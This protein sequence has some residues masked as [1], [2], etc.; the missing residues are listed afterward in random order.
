T[1]ASA[2][3]AL[4]QLRSTQQSGDEV[5]NR[6]ATGLR[7]QSAGDN[8]AFFLVS[9]K[10]RGDLVVLSGLRDNLGQQEGIFAAAL[11]GARQL[12]RTLDAVAGVITAAQQGVALDELEVAFNALL[13]QASEALSSAG[14]QDTNLLRDDSANTTVIGLDR[15]GNGLGFQ[16]IGVQGRDLDRFAYD[17]SGYEEGTRFVIEAESYD[18][19]IGNRGYA[20]EESE[21]NAGYLVWGDDP[22]VGQINYATSALARAFA[23][24]LDYELEFSEAGRYYFAFRGIGPDE[25]SNSI[26]IGIDGTPL[27]ANSRVTIDDPSG[28]PEWGSETQ[29]LPGTPATIDIIAPGSYTL[30]I[31]G[32]ENRTL[33]D[34]F[35][36]SLDT[37][38]LTGES[39]ALGA[40]TAKTGSTR[41]DFFAHL[42]QGESRISTTGFTEVL[43]TLRPSLSAGF[44]EQA[45]TVLDGLRSKLNREISQIGAYRER[46]V[47]Q[48]R[49]LSDLTDAL[50]L[51]VASLVEADL[52]VEA[53]R[54]AAIEV[55]ERLTAQSLSIANQRPATILQ[56]FR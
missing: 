37:T 2:Q 14:F 6:L 35:V 29:F 19:N 20:W 7:I 39:E 4:V 17:A 27:T 54:L 26:H 38:Q 42:D 52:Q 25:Q 46:I 53:S 34:G 32:R 24:R 15:S 16:T 18:L 56:L 43:S 55:Q 48:D 1:N 8:P 50:D 28:V 41:L 44:A 3:T 45:F 12:N 51:S 33:L 22:S 23:P 9:N 47:Q 40:E 10:T 30:N 13:Q 21:D 31:W 49:F 5:R 11:S 36:L